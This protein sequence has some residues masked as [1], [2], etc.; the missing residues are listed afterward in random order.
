ML[1][2]IQE[3]DIS[4]LLAINDFQGNAFLDKAFLLIT[5]KLTWIPLYIF[6]LL[7]YAWQR[8][9]KSALVFLGITIVVVGLCDLLSVHA[10]KNVFERLRPCHNPELVG[11]VKT[12]SNKCGG[13]FG[14][15]SSHATNHFGLAMWFVLVFTKN[16]NWYRWPFW[17]WAALIAISRVYLGVHYP[18]D[19]IVGGLLGVLIAQLI[20]RFT[21]HKMEWI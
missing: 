11:L 5:N 3:F 16:F 8:G 2:I 4:L 20:W 13:K 9:W 7:Y 12:I 18:T 19:V 6:M 1:N 15:V 10:F 17:L 14:F 21:H